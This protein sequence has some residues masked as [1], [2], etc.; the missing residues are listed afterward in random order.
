MRNYPFR[1]ALVYFIMASAWIFFS[2]MAT[3]QIVP[4]EHLTTAQSIKG[5]SFV[6]LSALILFLITRYYYSQVQKNERDFKR[7]FEDNPHPMWVYDIETLRFLVVNDAAVEKYGYSKQEFRNMTIADIRPE[8]DK[9]ALAM[10]V[11]SIQN[12]IYLD[13]GIWRHKDKN[14]RSFFVKIASHSSTFEK[15]QA[16]VV[17]AMDE[18]EQIEVHPLP[19]KEAIEHVLKSPHLRLPSAFGLLLYAREHPECL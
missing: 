9:L 16:R 13:S 15:H 11:K 5:V 3:E 19:L 10:F 14:G 2:D 18:D 1:I 6:I 12:K 4:A 7:L 17:L 8:E